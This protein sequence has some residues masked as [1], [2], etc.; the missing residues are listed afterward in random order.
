VRD[1]DFVCFLSK[2]VDSIFSK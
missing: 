1:T 2:V